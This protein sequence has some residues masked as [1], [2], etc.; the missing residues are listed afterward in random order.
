VEVLSSRILLHP[1]DL[2]R[3]RHFYRDVL[4]LAV[5]REF[6]FLADPSVVFFLGALLEISGPTAN[7]PGRSVH[8]WLQVPG[9][10]GRM[11][12]GRQRGRAVAPGR[13]DGYAF[14][15]A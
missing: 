6:R 2:A 12:R 11:N 13:A 15:P 5:Y 4:G 3:S 10:G 7:P 14:R 9:R 1:V 8:I